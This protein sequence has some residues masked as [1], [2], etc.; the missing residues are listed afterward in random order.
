MILN[1]VIEWFSGTSSMRMPAYRRR[2][3]RLQNAWH[4]HCAQGRLTTDSLGAPLGHHVYR[5]R[6][7]A[8]DELATVLEHML[9]IN[10]MVGITACRDST[11]GQGRRAGAKQH[12]LGVT[13]NACT[14]YSLVEV[15]AESAFTPCGCMALLDEGSWSE[16]WGNGNHHLGARC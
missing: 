3:A 8:A 2:T 11:A 15:G 1:I 4:A 6:N 14:T 13:A 10:L 5:E 9:E 7:E 16:G 12:L